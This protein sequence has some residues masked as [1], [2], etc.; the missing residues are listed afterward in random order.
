MNRRNG[1][2]QGIK[3]SLSVVNTSSQGLSK[4][5]ARLH[6]PTWIKPEVVTCTCAPPATSGNLQVRLVPSPAGLV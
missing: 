5:L 3:A 4:A 1:V 6:Y 2:L